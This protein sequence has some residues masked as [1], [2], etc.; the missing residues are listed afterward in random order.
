MQNIEN[1]YKDIDYDIFKQ[2][3]DRS[4]INKNKLKIIKNNTKDL[5]N[6]NFDSLEAS[7]APLV[8]DN[9]LAG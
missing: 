2:P 4:I 7:S 5:I 3:K 6:I 9:K 1:L 8:I